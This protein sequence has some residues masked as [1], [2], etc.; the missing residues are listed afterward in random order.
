MR[1]VILTVGPRASG[2]SEFCEKVVKVDPTIV[3]VSRDK[4]LIEL[5][6]STSLD[7]YTGGHY[8]AHEQ[9]WKAVEEKLKSD[10][11][12]MILDTWNGTSRERLDII[13]RLRDLG[14]NR[15]QA[16][17]FVTPLEYVNQWFWQKPG[18]ARM[19]EIRAVQSQ[20]CVFY[21]DDTPR[22]DYELFHRLALRINSDGFDR[23][24]KVNP[25]ITQP[26]QIL[27]M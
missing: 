8:Y 13:H 22:T 10:G 2:K 4:L 21:G 1:E 11:L 15:V 27:V 7:P 14:T 24:T 12:R 19:S 3:L 6:G 25:L 17:Y 23:V 26:E 16:W 18:V 5:F 20:G 9:L